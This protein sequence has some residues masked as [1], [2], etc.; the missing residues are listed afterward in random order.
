MSRNWSIHIVP[1]SHLDYGWA[2]SP[3][4]CF[5]YVSEIIRTAIDDL[6]ESAPEYRFTIEYAL[7][8]QHFLEV[9]PEYLPQVKR[10]VADGR[11]E[12]CP[13]M[14]GL[15]EHWLDGES[16]IHQLVRGKRWLRE[17]LD[18]DAMTAQH[19]DLPGHIRQIP[20]MLKLAEID[21]LAYSRYHPPMP[22][23]RWRGPD[24]TEVMACCHM[25]EPY[26][27]IYHNNW[28]GYGLGWALFVNNT[29]ME[30]VYKDL[31]P[32]L[33]QRDRC[34]PKD[35]DALLMGC[36]S[37]LQPGDPTMLER[38]SQWNERFP[39][40]PIRPSTISE[41]FRAVDPAKL[42]V[43]EGEAPYSFFAITAI[44]PDTALEM[45][46]GD[47]LVTAAEKWSSFAQ[48]SGLGRVQRGRLE[49]ARDAFFLPHDH[50]I[51]GRRGEVNDQERHKDA[52]TARLE[53]ESIA[54][55]NAMKFTVHVDFKQLEAGACPITVF[56]PLSWMRTDVVETYIE[57]P[58]SKIAGLHMT[59]VDGK[60]V[61]T[62]IVCTEDRFG[63]SRVEFVFVAEDVPPH[64]YTT[65]Y[66]RPSQEAE[67]VATTLRVSPARLEN[68]VF[69]IRLRKH[70]ITG[71][72]WRGQELARKG[73][74]RFNE[75]YMLHAPLCNVEAGPW[76]VDETYTGKEWDAKMLRTEVLEAGP[77]RARIRLSGRIQGSR[78]EQEV[79][80]YERLDRADFH[81]RVH[82]KPKLHTQTR[83][84]YPF[85]IGDGVATYESPYGTVRLGKDEMPYTFRGTGERWVQKWMDISNKDFG[86]TMATRHT[87]NRID[88]KTIEPILLRTALDCGTV[89]HHPDQDK[90]YEFD[91]AL[92][93]HE[94][95]WQQCA[96]YRAGW[97]FNNPL[98][99]CNWTS[100]FPI[101]PLRRSHKLPERDSFLKVSGKNVVVTAVA[102]SHDDPEAFV[103]RLVEFCGRSCA[104]TLT[105]PR[106][107]AEAIE[108]NL[109]ERPSGPVTRKGN[110]VRLKVR[111][112]GIHS[113]KV[114]LRG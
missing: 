64:G 66:V 103:V 40:A 54:Q 15:I 22:L 77:V 63:C 29:D 99:S 18:Y 49:R 41:F 91:Y 90:T 4:E 12:I 98:Q 94:K 67:K 20:Q 30:H 73:R 114:R 101:K 68:T 6:E 26:D 56:N 38:L 57:A 50:N 69:K 83:V 28:E 47:N 3:G 109:L 10:L 32:I 108:T 60:P 24:G 80:L 14:T 42:P 11:L 93:P 37:D 48:W 45:R 62:Q 21:N 110:T 1:A 33:E 19:T 13:T 95:G 16:L 113:V 111:R 105:F 53:G 59:D 88:E 8:M 31:P 79:S 84:V 65:F 78:I 112:N 87:P 75:I 39:D 100:C 81:Q 34:W 106:P 102:P 82:Y 43:Y 27:A 70:R 96:G 46:Q 76:Q 104:V 97:A 72:T 7:F 55:E 44:D 89:F 5:A 86:V 85:R 61:P 9:Y 107:V 74:R 35:V 71:L 92:Y 17:H 52:W 2:A 51:N 23:H 36:E 25:Q 58:L